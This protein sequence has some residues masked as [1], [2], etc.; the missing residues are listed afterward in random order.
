MML[1]FK[2]ID[3][4]KS[5]IT[6]YIVIYKEDFCCQLLQKS[7]RFSVFFNRTRISRLLKL[8]Q[9]H[10]FSWQSDITINYTYCTYTR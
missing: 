10:R 7:F 5:E 9:N 8:N 2:N 1:I 6:E 3:E 4:I